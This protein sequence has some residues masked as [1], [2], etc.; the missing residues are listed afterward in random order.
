MRILISSPIDI[1]SSLTIQ[2]IAKTG[3]CSGEPATIHAVVEDGIDIKR[4]PGTREEMLEL[5]GILNARIR[6]HSGDLDREMIREASKGGYEMIV[7]GMRT[8]RKFR[9]GFM[10][11]P[12][13]IRLLN[14]SLSPVVVVKDR[15]TDVHRVLLCDSGAGIDPDLCSMTAHFLKRLKYVEE[16]SIL[17][18]MSQI[19][20]GP[21]V[22]GQQLRAN[23]DELIKENS[24]GGLILKRDIDLLAKSGIPVSAKIRH[25]LVVEEILRELNVGD[26]GLVVIGAHYSKGWQGLLLDDL[27]TKIL[28]HVAEPIL[29]VTRNPLSGDQK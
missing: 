3:L 24:L 15:V 21:G 20:A 7:A 19:S 14:N 28:Q 16:I 13:I 6:I 17:H 29:V 8:I 1:T 12:S 4:T 18:V 26:Y 2:F 25:G 11:K 23:S 10:R 22:V 5:P 9:D 27:A